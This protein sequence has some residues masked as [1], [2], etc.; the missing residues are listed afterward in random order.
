MQVDQVV[1]DARDAISVK[2]VYGEP[3]EKN[4]LLFIPVATVAGGGGAGNGHDKDGGS[5]DG[6][7]FGTAGRPAGAYV[8]KDGGVQWRPAVD[9]NRLISTLGKVVIVWLL[10]R[11][12][13][14]RPVRA[15]TGCCASH[16]Q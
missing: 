10:T 3:V 12:R 6:G 4:G 11:G 8:I 15:T 2:R 5:G 14:G 9:V 1:R 13:R 16:R 7:G